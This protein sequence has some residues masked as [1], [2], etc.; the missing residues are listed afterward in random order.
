[1][2]DGFHKD[3]REIDG[4]AVNF[5]MGGEGPP[6]LLLHGY[7]QTH[8]MWHK[9]APLMAPHYTLVMADLRGYGDSGKPPTDARHIPYSKRAMAA[10]LAGLMA[11][12]GFARFAVVGHDRGGRVGHRLAAD[13]GDRVARLAVL[14]IAP[15]EHM[16]RLT[17]MEFATGYYHWFFLIQPAD[18]PER[19]IGA[20][21]EYFLRRKMGHWSADG[22]V[23]DAAAMAEYVRCFSMPETI[24][25]SCEDYRAAATIDLEHDRAD[26]A[27]GRRLTCPLL[28]LWGARGLVGRKFDVLAAWRERAE[29]VAGGTVDCGHFLAEESPDDTFA[30]LREFL[31]DGPWD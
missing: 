2:L 9:L 1:M 26:M 18:M 28:A 24:H 20:D 30:R 6:V 7:P 23:F 14:D 4:V 17:D 3:R 11:D 13:H 19:M 31:G 10:D 25:A 16:Y 8:A 27:A 29:N 5:R 15:T 22:A 21:P 12:L